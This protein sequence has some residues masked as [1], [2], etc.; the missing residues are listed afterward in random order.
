MCWHLCVTEA[1]LGVH[2]AQD[3]GVDSGGFGRLISKM[4]AQPALQQVDLQMLFEHPTVRSLAEA[5]VALSEGG[6]DSDEEGEAEVASL[7]DGFLARL[8]ATPHAVCAESGC[9]GMSCRQL[10]KLAVSYQHLLHQTLRAKRQPETREPEPCVAICLE[11]PERLAAMVAAVREGCAFCVLEP[12][13]DVQEQLRVA[14][15]QLLLAS[16]AEATWTC[17]EQHCK[18]LAPEA[19]WPQSAR[20]CAVPLE[21]SRSFMLARLAGS[22]NIRS[23]AEVTCSLL[24]VSSAALPGKLPKQ[25]RGLASGTCCIALATAGTSATAG[26][27]GDRFMWLL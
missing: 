6:S 7:L 22:H 10:F 16:K 2:F 26:G 23:R 9:Q 15:P 24:D 4:R 12:R 5:L 3:L 20:H 19:A 1:L 14:K 13:C 25:R 27:Y 21:K 8:E 18:L 11:L 17:L